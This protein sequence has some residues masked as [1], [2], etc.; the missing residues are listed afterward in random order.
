[1]STQNTT[2]AQGDAALF[3]GATPSDVDDDAPDTE[4][5]VGR[6]QAKAQALDAFHARTPKP[7]RGGE[8]G[9]NAVPVPFLRL[10]PGA[11]LVP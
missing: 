7:P 11:H 6:G 10:T 2:I 8:H 5:P 1:M 9:G 4:D 3:A